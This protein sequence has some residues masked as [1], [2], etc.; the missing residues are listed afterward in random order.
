MADDAAQH[1]RYKGAVDVPVDARGVAMKVLMLV[2]AT[3]V[4][5]PP[6]A[7][8]QADEVFAGYS[9][10]LSRTLAASTSPRDWALQSRNAWF[11]AR[12]MQSGAGDGGL[13]R[14][15]AAAA[16]NDRLVQ[17]LWASADTEQAGCTAARPCPER[18]SALAR[19]EPDNAAAWLPLLA[20]AARTKDEAGIDA[21]LAR[22][23]AAT[24]HDDLFVENAV[25]W[26]AVYRR[27]P[28][29]EFGADYTGPRD[30]V[31]LAIVAAIAR[32]AAMPLSAASYKTCDKAANPQAPARRFEDCAR[33]GRLMLSNGNSVIARRLGAPYLRKSGGM[34]AAELAAVRELDWRQA[35]SARLARRLE[36]DPAEMRRYFADLAS[37]GSEI[38]AQE[39]QLQRAGLALTPPPEWKP[40]ALPTP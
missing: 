26:E 27:Y 37:T 22:M 33:L 34:G 18:L 2:L 5:N 25:A 6:A 31:Y 24:R 8:A 13:L 35:Q 19:L 10:Q 11:D 9:R 7:K 38:A 1:G 21:A 3:L 40:A 4:A 14:K 15:A 23:A 36:S 29:P 20:E 28:M 30:P 16:P 39:L 32:A 17:W 12:T